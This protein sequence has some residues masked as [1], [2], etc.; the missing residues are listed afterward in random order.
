MDDQLTFRIPRALAR[1][2]ARKAK[3]R[4]VPRAQ[5]LR[6]ALTAYLAPGPVPA[7]PGADAWERV[8]DYV[9]SMPLDHPAI[10]ADDVARRIREHNWRDAG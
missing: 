1:A 6:E 2:L 5:L 4:A 7:A 3:E 8:R 10:E 9:G